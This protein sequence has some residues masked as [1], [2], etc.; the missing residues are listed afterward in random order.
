MVLGS[1]FRDPGKE[2]R[3]PEKTYYR[4]RIQGSKRHRIPDPQHC[5]TAEKTIPVYAKKQTLCTGTH[6]MKF[7]YRTT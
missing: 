3:D 7:L 2:I 1:G 5:T 6:Y 4:F